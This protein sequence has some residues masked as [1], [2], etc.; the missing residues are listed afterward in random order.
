MV[1]PHTFVD[2][3]QPALSNALPTRCGFLPLSTEPFSL[4]AKFHSS[5]YAEKT[6]FDPQAA[7]RPVKTLRELEE[8]WGYPN[9]S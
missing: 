9:R 8:H 2:N 1:K 5:V 4:K 7:A 6:R 3:R